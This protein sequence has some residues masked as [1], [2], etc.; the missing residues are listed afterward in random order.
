MAKYKGIVK[1]REPWLQK[2][3]IIA[4]VFMIF[5]EIASGMWTYLGA[6]LV[7]L[8]A[9]FLKKEQNVSEEGVDTVLKLFGYE[10]HSL[11]TWDEI[12]AMRTDHKKQKP[13]VVLTM[14]KDVNLR[15][16]V[17]KAS[18]CKAVLEMAKAINPLINIDDEEDME[19][20]RKENALRAQKAAAARKK[21]KK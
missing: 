14:A 16:Y 21:K 17:M 7:A 12:T 19:K 15:S 6:T 8:L 13:K 5:L 20:I 18:D 3:I 9:C 2:A 11:W 10:H 4:A 1:E